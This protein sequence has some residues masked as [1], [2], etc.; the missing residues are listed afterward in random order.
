M[1]KNRRHNVLQADLLRTCFERYDGR[2]ASGA[3]ANN[4]LVYENI[5]TNPWLESRLYDSLEIL[6]SYHKPDMLVAN[7]T[8]ANRIGI[9]LAWRLGTALLLLSKDTAT[10]ALGF[11]DDEAQ[12]VYTA[13]R[14]IIVEDVIN[15]LST[16]RRTMALPGIA[17]RT[18]AC[19]DA[20]DRGDR[21][22][23]PDLGIAVEAVVRMP[24]PAVLPED[25]NLWKYADTL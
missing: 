8:G 24:I 3:T 14:I 10:K 21:R 9:E 23:R 13:S 7:P 5:R 4:K 19:I 12:N 18:V 15:S 1:Y 20:I 17:E 25:D 11:L 16:T 6:V 2:Y 22:N